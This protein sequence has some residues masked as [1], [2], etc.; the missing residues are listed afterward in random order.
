MRNDPRNVEWRNYKLLTGFHARIKLVIMLKHIFLTGVVFG[1]VFF[2]I[3]FAGPVIFSP[4]SN[5][6]PLIGIFITGPLGFCLG[7]VAGIVRHFLSKGK[8]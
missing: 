5:Q 2:L 3:G 8:S 4:E 6:G 1:V 7:I